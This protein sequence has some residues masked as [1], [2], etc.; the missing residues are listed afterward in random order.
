MPKPIIKTDVYE[1]DIERHR[2]YLMSADRQL[3]TQEESIKKIAKAILS[4]E[5]NQLILSHDPLNFRARILSWNAA[6]NTVEY[7]LL[8]TAEKKSCEAPA[9]LGHTTVK[10]RNLTLNTLTP[11]VD[12]CW[13]SA[14]FHALI[15]LISAPFQTAKTKKTEQI[16]SLDHPL[17]QAA[18]AVTFD[19]AKEL[20]KGSS[21]ATL[22][23]DASRNASEL[24]QVVD[25]P[26][27]QKEFIDKLLHRYQRGGNHPIILPF[28]IGEG[29]NF[30]PYVLVFNGSL[31]RATRYTFSA[32]TAESQV[33][34]EATYELSFLNFSKFMQELLA[35]I[36]REMENKPAKAKEGKSM[37]LYE[38]FA[39]L[40]DPF[41]KL[42]NYKKAPTPEGP[43]QPCRIVDELLLHN[44]K[45]EPNTEKTA[46]ASLD[47]LKLIC[48]LVKN[49]INPILADPNAEAETKTSFYSKVVTYLTTYLNDPENCISE[50]QRSKILQ[51]L[52]KNLKQLRHYY[53]QSHGEEV[54]TS[55][56]QPLEESLKLHLDPSE[57]LRKVEQ[58]HL[59]KLNT[60]AVSLQQ[61]VDRVIT[62][63]EE[64][65]SKAASRAAQQLLAQ[66]EHPLDP[67]MVQTLS[68]PNASLA[69]RTAAL[70]RMNQY[71]N[72]I[73]QLFDQRQFAPTK[74]R[75]LA[76]MQAL[77]GPMGIHYGETTFWDS[78]QGEEILQWMESLEKLSKLVWER[79]VKTWDVKLD[80]VMTLEARIV[81]TTNIRKLYML[82]HAHMRQE[83]EGKYGVSASESG[84]SIWDFLNAI[85][86]GQKARELNIEKKYLPF[87]FFNASKGA[88]AAFN[89]DCLPNDNLISTCLFTSDYAYIFGSDPKLNERWLQCK[90][91]LHE[92]QKVYS[93]GNGAFALREFYKAYHQL[94]DIDGNKPLL[95]RLDSA[96]QGFV[97]DPN[98]PALDFI[99]PQLLQVMRHEHRFSML[100]SIANEYSCSLI[101]SYSNVFEVAF[102]RL[103]NKAE[104]SEWIAKVK[105]SLASMP[106]VDMKLDKR[107]EKF[108]MIPC[109]RL[110]SLQT[111]TSLALRSSE[112]ARSQ[113]F[114]SP[115]YDNITTEYTGEI[116]TRMVGKAMG[117]DN[118]P[119]CYAHHCRDATHHL[120]PIQEWKL[121]GTAL[122]SDPREH[123]YKGKQRLDDLE[124][125]MVN[126]GKMGRFSPTSIKASLEFILRYPELINQ[127]R[128]QHRL[129][130]V[131]FNPTLMFRALATEPLF[132]VRFGPLLQEV[133]DKVP[134]GDQATKLF[135]MDLCQR[136]RESADAFL[137]IA[138]SY[139][140]NVPL[141]SFVEDIYG[142]RPLELV[143]GFPDQ[144]QAITSPL[145]KYPPEVIH[146]W[147]SLNNETSDQKLFATYLLDFVQKP[148][149]FPRTSQHFINALQAFYILQA[150]PTPGG[151]PFV[152]TTALNE[153]RS[154]FNFRLGEGL[155]RSEGLR[156]EVLAGITKRPRTHWQP[157]ADSKVIYTLVGDNAV[158]VN[159]LTGEG[160]S[161]RILDA[162]ECSLPPSVLSSGD[163]EELFGNERPLAKAHVK[164][165]GKV[166]YTWFY[167]G[168]EY[169]ATLKPTEA[170]SWFRGTIYQIYK[171]EKYGYHR[172][173]VKK[174]NLQI[175]TLLTKNG[176]WQHSIRKEE[177]YLAPL[178]NDLRRQRI[179]VYFDSTTRSWDLKLTAASMGEG[180][181]QLW[182]CQEP[183]RQYTSAMGCVTPK[184]TLYL[185]GKDKKTLKAIVLSE[186]MTLQRKSGDDWRD[187]KR[188]NW[189]WWLQKTDEVVQMFGE[190]F[191]QFILPLRDVSSDGLGAKE[192]W[193]YPYSI[194]STGK[195][196]C[197]RTF[198]KPSDDEETPQPLKLSWSHKEGWRGTHAAFLYM[199]YASWRQG[200]LAAAAKWLN[201]MTT[202]GHSE[203][204]DIDQL[205]V[206]IELFKN[207]PPTTSVQNAFC[208]KLGLNL[209]ILERE[210]KGAL[211][212]TDNLVETIPLLPMYAERY[213]RDIKEL[214]IK[215]RLIDKNL[216]ITPSEIAEFVCLFPDNQF[217][218]FEVSLTPLRVLSLPTPTSDDVA[219]LVECLKQFTLSKES[220][221]DSLHQLEGSYPKRETVLAHFWDIWN[222]IL[223][224]ED[225]KLKDYLFLFAPITP[226]ERA[227]D[228]ALHMQINK[229]VD[230]ARRMLILLLIKKEEAKKDSSKDFEP[231]D[232]E[233][234]RK[235]GVNQF[236]KAFPGE[237]I[238]IEDLHSLPAYKI[239]RLL[240]LDEKTQQKYIDAT[241]TLLNR[242]VELFAPKTP[243][244]MTPD[245][246]LIAGNKGE[247][248]T[249]SSGP[250]PLPK[251]AALQSEVAKPYVSRSLP[252]N[253]VP[254][255]KDWHAFFE[256]E[257]ISGELAARK[258]AIA[259]YLTGDSSPMEVAKNEMLKRSVEQAAHKM[260]AQH[261]VLKAEEIAN[262]KSSIKSR[263]GDLETEMTGYRDDILTF[264]RQYASSLGIVPLFASRTPSDQELI[265]A[266]LNSYVDMRWGK[267]ADPAKVEQIEQKITYY[268][269]VATEHQQLQKASVITDK[270]SQRL[271]KEPRFAQS[272]EWKLESI[273][274][275]RHLSEGSNRHR[276]ILTS[277][278]GKKVLDPRLGGITRAYLVDEYLNHQI[279]RTLAIEA[280]EELL[281]GR[282]NK[283]I[284][285]RMG[286]G[287]S[288][289]IMRK[290][291]MML[292][293]RG[294]NPTVIFTEKLL[295]Q[296]VGFMDPNAYVFNYDR[297]NGIDLKKRLTQD[298]QHSLEVD[299]LKK[300]KQ[301]LVS[302][303]AQG[304]YIITTPERLAGLINKKA[305][306]D[307]DLITYNA[308]GQQVELQRTYEKLCLIQDLLPHF[309]GAQ[310][311]FL[312]DEDVNLD[313][314]VEF[315]YSYGKDEDLDHV[316]IDMAD[317]MMQWLLVKEIPAGEF[318][319]LV[320]AREKVLNGQLTAIPPLELPNIFNE[321]VQFAAQ[322]ETYWCSVGFTPEQFA[323]IREEILPFITKPAV[324]PDRIAQLF[325]TRSTSPD[326]EKALQH[327][328]NFKLYITSTFDT[329][330]NTHPDFQRVIKKSTGC[331][332]VPGEDG[333][334]K[335]SYQFGA[336]L[337]LIGHHYLYYAVNP[338]SKEYFDR[339]IRELATT[340]PWDAWVKS[341][342][343]MNAYEKLKMKESYKERLLFCKYLLKDS[344][345]IKHFRYQLICRQQDIYLGTPKFLL[346]GTGSPFAINMAT[347]S[348]QEED[349]DV[350]TGEMFLKVDFNA[351][352]KVFGDIRADLSNA[353]SQP[354]HSAII[355]QAYSVGGNDAKTVIEE[356]RTQNRGRQFIFVDTTSRD[357]KIWHVGGDVIQEYHS[358]QVSRDEALFYYGPPDSRG[359]DFRIPRRPLV[360]NQKMIA[361]PYVGPTTTLDEYNQTI[362]R[363]RELGFDYEIHI[364]QAMAARIK[365]WSGLEPQDI[366]VGHVI[367]DIKKRTLV[368]MVHQNP[369]AATYAISSI[370]RK[371]ILPALRA[372]SPINDYVA[373]TE[374]YRG[375][376]LEDRNQTWQEA[377]QSA[378][379]L[380][381]IPFLRR[382]YQKA[383]DRAN[384]MWDAALKNILKQSNT[385]TDDQDIIDLKKLLEQGQGSPVLRQVYMAHKAVMEELESDL[386][387]LDGLELYYAKYLPRENLEQDYSTKER[388]IKVMTHAQVQLHVQQQTHTLLEKYEDESVPI[389]FVLDELISDDWTHVVTHR[390]MHLDKPTKAANSWRVPNCVKADLTQLRMSVQASRLLGA[391]NTP[392]VPSGYILVVQGQ[393]GYKFCV[394]T[395]GEWS[396]Q[397]ARL[398][399]DKRLKT[400]ADER[401][402]LYPL[403][404]PKPG[405]VLLIDQSADA[406][407]ENTKEFLEGCAR[408][409]FM[410]GWTRL[411]ERELELLKDWLINMPKQKLDE[412]RADFVKRDLKD[413]VE[414][415]ASLVS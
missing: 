313:P 197:K 381:P 224:D 172:V 163:Y 268:L 415:I 102:G 374:A 123:P 297:R 64:K 94:D 149:Q 276:Y 105:E 106:R 188:P 409:R 385:K 284:K 30:V 179:R 252:L 397:V 29:K 272:V 304:R 134:A 12:R 279:S 193:I 361:H 195:A 266:L 39:D 185:T 342:N 382:Q 18:F 398:L 217:M 380:A 1:V 210:L 316:S 271:E 255:N 152:Q 110:I 394:I 204:E 26:D 86:Q 161:V 341:L 77:P 139:K 251:L 27:K 244:L 67:I 41:K 241:S 38:V 325:E 121:E 391:I 176:I 174:D 125:D 400:V 184:S 112:R 315:N 373:L 198:I 249:T 34:S 8:E 44:G 91:F 347:P 40:A 258:S 226:D 248:T 218:R 237:P 283:F 243:L 178:N 15:S 99:P 280:L 166:E 95:K 334:E 76:L 71:L 333:V 254:A 6:T 321:F 339:K 345:Y 335:P 232:L 402:G 414:L 219:A 350:I 222:L 144:H 160:F 131:C 209:S 289:F 253:D 151:H 223:T 53:I 57:G 47:P 133:I 330:F 378:L 386:R 60:K 322:D 327:L 190:D 175:L 262:L 263:L 155:S 62:Q 98:D 319:K 14:L 343:G 194:Q 201:L 299:H 111:K 167:K 154:R 264:A 169:S 298:E 138:N 245:G 323:V 114:L 140:N 88:I 22:L 305:E 83:F 250:H 32:P 43:F 384:I 360:N 358:D 318:P 5:C 301:T 46:Q 403:D 365:S 309:S 376:Y 233:A 109:Y 410:L 13:L 147:F 269:L 132:F 61:Q 369:K 56:L 126:D 74:E 332:I 85:A 9:D 344:G 225:A 156:N 37:P 228:Q 278:D 261:H 182:V 68:N 55:A 326:L 353:A 240:K 97:S 290:A 338:P 395:A 192:F 120:D 150:A 234:L 359:I 312:I 214:V 242:F 370:L 236:R 351:P 72:E 153:A 118:E 324:I 129:I 164:E 113:S 128:V 349:L 59:E 31:M 101:P 227:R 119:I 66:L 306:L 49:P 407:L 45:L 317:Q 89:T 256:A 356:I 58:E 362:G 23:E 288:T 81:L 33:T 191:R 274:L 346:S 281:Q 92:I 143:T 257:D 24:Q 80:P 73:D 205:K 412:L 162:A 142:I 108:E 411:G 367:N 408:L 229:A 292:Q 7:E 48:T 265:Q 273:D 104:G 238:D 295:K 115:R 203:K 375:L 389:R 357:K 173:L 287:K 51:V 368:N 311:P 135:L 124:S 148:Q 247:I 220:K 96:F 296:S 337:E 300:L 329:L 352:V 130:Q 171:G 103:F 260:N 302:V 212:L 206:I 145:P 84:L 183:L 69:E 165:D 35:A 404:P 291:A 202:Q 87:I 122:N 82:Y 16:A 200:D 42:F 21:V 230:I 20:F 275:H 3:N 17:N 19:F 320:E 137:E 348:Q 372:T 199:V 310:R 314:S 406:P 52:S 158:R 70:A 208:L 54:A 181:E 294:L 189:Q 36:P 215:Q 141:D 10:I 413:S 390:T 388:Q 307:A 168:V 331:V 177:S 159:L 392:N 303:E 235:G 186:T 371:H 100:D 107:W 79:A 282:D 401:I 187:V 399:E 90:H 4:K 366:K 207:S 267:I 340:P 328:G 355:N 63:T 28:G 387:L 270:L 221:I 336:I 136:I 246:K 383:K 405:Q 25:N 157:V 393:S 196:G 75:L 364:D 11:K 285:L 354:H 377:F 2:F 211:G 116:P 170:T 78:L 396:E 379:T 146:N 216:V 127:P 308:R 363:I 293:R 93:N 50:E 231:G 65:P 117:V 277:G 259:A 180:S 239:L 213:V 286:L